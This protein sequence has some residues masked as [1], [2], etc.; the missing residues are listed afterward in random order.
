MTEGA[1][2]LTLSPFRIRRRPV[3]RTNDGGMIPPG[4]VLN[5]GGKDAKLRLLY[6]I[7]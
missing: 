6:L 2:S 3:C 5:V 4:I 1:V 7:Q